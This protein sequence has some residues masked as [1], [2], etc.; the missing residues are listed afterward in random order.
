MSLDMTAPVLPFQ[1]P[2]DRGHGPVNV[3]FSD[4]AI[5]TLHLDPA[6]YSGKNASI[7]YWQGPIQDKSYPWTGFSTL[8]TYTSE[9]HDLHPNVTTG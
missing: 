2:W 1:N 9:I 3:S 7:I 4:E 5:A 6:V 8:A